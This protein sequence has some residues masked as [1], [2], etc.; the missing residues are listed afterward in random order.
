MRS[1]EGGRIEWRGLGGKLEWGRNWC[2]PGDMREETLIRIRASRGK[3]VRMGEGRRSWGRGYRKNRDRG[4]NEK[5][6]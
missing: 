2:R 3:R 4:Q 1:K 5:G 6:T